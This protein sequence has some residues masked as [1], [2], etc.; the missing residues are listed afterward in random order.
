MLELDPMTT[1]V[2]VMIFYTNNVANGTHAPYTQTA[3]EPDTSAVVVNCLFFA[4]LSA[5]LFAALASV[6]ALQWVAD[7]DAAITRGGSS[8]EDRAKRRQFRYAGVISWKMSEIIAALP[9]LLYF[10]VILFFAGLILWMWVI[11]HAVGAVVAGCTAVAVLFYIMTTMIAVAFVS[12]PFRTP[13]S[14]GIYSLIHLPFS[15]L[16][17][18]MRAMRIPTI[19][20]WIKS[21]HALY[22]S[23]GREDQAV[24]QRWTLGKD[25]LIWLANQLSI[26]QDSYQRLLLLVGTLPSLREE[27]LPSFNP[28]EASWYQIFD[29]L[30]W[31]YLRTG[32]SAIASREERRRGMEILQRCYK[33]P[34]VQNLVDPVGREELGEYNHRAYWSQYCGSAEDGPW[35]ISHD[36]PN[37]LFLLLRDIPCPSQFSSQ[38]IDVAVR[39]S[40]WRN[41]V[42][43]DPQAW[44]DVFS[45]ATSLPSEF[46][47]ACVTT[48]GNFCRGEN[49]L[50]CHDAELELYNTIVGKAWEISTQR[51]D[52][53]PVAA[54]P[55]IR[56]YEAILLGSGIGHIA[57]GSPLIAPFV[58][59]KILQQASAKDHAAH[60]LMTRVFS[61]TIYQA[62]KADSASQVKD[63]IAMLWLR[64]SNPV[65][66]DW[67]Y[68]H[69]THGGYLPVD[70]MSDW[71]RNAESVPNILEILRHLAE[72]Q[73]RNPAI[74][75]LW[76]TTANDKVVD[77]HFVEALQ[78]LDQLMSMGCTDH[79]HCM[80]VNLVCQ[81]LELEPYVNFDHYFTPSRLE[82]LDFLKDHCLRVL[83][84]C[85]RG[86]EFLSLVA[87]SK[88]YDEAPRVSLYRVVKFIYKRFSSIDSPAA[89]QLQA[90]LWPIACRDT[91][92]CETAMQDAITLVSF[93]QVLV[94]E[95]N[96]I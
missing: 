26:S 22:T 44:D 67:D 93:R 19:P 9:L 33:V 79:D 94:V 5:S 34:V 6:V 48:F 58:Y 77:P 64:P 8:P 52:L 3:F 96:L 30:G 10:S 31:G 49:W 70:I 69:R 88:A 82:S 42:E 41:K 85:A 35:T 12:A 38:E 43:K 25:A 4:S 65:T 21:R 75:P 63:V 74:G 37:H 68:L 61:G 46:F 16:H 90:S 62:S 45:N 92:L 13:L 53:L 83:V 27:H 39:L 15:V 51:D 29:L 40:E 78:T 87:V 60:T 86:P 50:A 73:R 2:D 89:L 80:L 56:A 81:D 59:G 84:G 7:Y 54:K 32:S 20:S 17:W 95:C 11:N 24:E 36:R 23:Y 57:K 14:R 66:R 18:L 1:M 55:L 76:R 72:A 71:I 47:S 28:A 91:S